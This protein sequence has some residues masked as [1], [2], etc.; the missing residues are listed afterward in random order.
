MGIRPNSQPNFIQLPGDS[1]FLN[2]GIIAQLETDCK[3]ER[4]ESK[5][6]GQKLCPG[7]IA[8]GRILDFAIGKGGS[9]VSLRKFH[10]LE[11]RPSELRGS[12]AAR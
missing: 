3:A 10:Q 8:R 11:R 12:F 6:C 1:V 4:T 7:H 2:G 9:V 5:I